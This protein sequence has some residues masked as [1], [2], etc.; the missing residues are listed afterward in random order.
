ME[1]GAKRLR[2]PGA[3]CLARSAAP[4]RSRLVSKDGPGYTPVAPDV[5]RYNSSRAHSARNFSAPA[6]GS[7]KDGDLSNG[8]FSEF[9]DARTSQELQRQIRQPRSPTGPAR[10]SAF[11][12]PAMGPEV[13]LSRMIFLGDAK[14]GDDAV[15]RL[16][17]LSHRFI[18]NRR[19]NGEEGRAFSAGSAPKQT[20][21]AG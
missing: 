4:S 6:F 7:Y 20:L 12:L 17:G 13:S 8:T 10:R 18:A 21:A 11:L 16:G 14:L 5:A 2:R 15:E 3:L 9:A 19:R 1:R